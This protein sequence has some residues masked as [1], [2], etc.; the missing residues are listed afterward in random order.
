MRLPLRWIAILRDQLSISLAATSG[1]HSSNEAVKLLLAGADVVM[2][3]SSL[4]RNGADHLETVFL[5]LQEWM[6]ERE[7]ESVQQMKGSMSRKNC[8]DPAGFE[9]ANYI[10]AIVTYV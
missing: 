7:Y 1:V 5:G 8:P 10:K 3:A 6:R 9:R 4:L 2:M